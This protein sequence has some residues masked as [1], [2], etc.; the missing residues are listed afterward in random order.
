MEKFS[1]DDYGQTIGYSFVGKDGHTELPKNIGTVKAVSST[2]YMFMEDK[3]EQAVSIVPCEQS[4]TFQSIDSQQ[5]YTKQHRDIGENFRYT[6][7]VD[8][9]I[10][11]RPFY[12]LQNQ[13]FDLEIVLCRD[14]DPRRQYEEYDGECASDEDVKDFFYNTEFELLVF[15][16]YVDFESKT[17][18]VKVS[19]M[20]LFIDQI[21]L[22]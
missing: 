17:S 7:P 9:M 12:S 1:L 16:S 8:P 14:Y 5:A 3:N 11:W 20:V 19:A 4:A 2:S 21:H 15:K 6:E 18:P 10:L 13:H 22:E